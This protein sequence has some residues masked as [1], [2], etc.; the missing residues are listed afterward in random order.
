[1]TPPLFSLLPSCTALNTVTE[2]TINTNVINVTKIKGAPEIP[3]G[4]V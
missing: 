2:L 3:N 1:M 4:A